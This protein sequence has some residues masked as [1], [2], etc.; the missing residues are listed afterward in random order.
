MKF[1]PF[2]FFRSRFRRNSFRKFGDVNEEPLHISDG[3]RTEGVLFEFQ[4]EINE[5]T[6]IEKF[7]KDSYVKL[8][9]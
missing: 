7:L 2:E 3:N 5:S 8:S 9:F 1:F 6:T 4:D